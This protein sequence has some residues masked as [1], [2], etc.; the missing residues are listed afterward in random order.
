MVRIDDSGDEVKCWMDY[1]N[2]VDQL[3]DEMREQSW[4]AR[5]AGLIMGKLGT[6]ASGVVTARPKNLTYNSKGEYW[7]L[8]IYAKNTKGGGKTVRDVYVPEQVKRELDNYQRERDLRPS[9]PYV[10]KSVDTVRRWVREAGDRLSQQGSDRW[11]HVS[12]HDFRRSWATYHLVEQDRSPRVMMEIGG[13]DSMEAMEPY[14]SKPSPSKIAE[15]MQ[16]D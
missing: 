2:E 15:E 7:Q 4:E 16:D 9:D 8:K 13:W 1:P 12:S 11:D 10:D 3:I 5:I 6:R 14:M